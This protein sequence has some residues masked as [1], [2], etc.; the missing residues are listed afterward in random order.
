MF[1][2]GWA[3]H[4]QAPKGWIVA[5]SHPKDYQMSVDRE[6]A[7]GGK[8]SARLKSIAAKTSGF[9]TLMQTFQAETFRGKRVRMSGYARSQDVSDWA[10]LWMRVDGPRGEPL[11]FDNMQQRPIK[12]TTE[13]TRYEI[14]LD[15][16]AQAE[17]IACGL[18]LTGRGEA[19]MD[20]LKFE[21][22]SKEILT[23][24]QSPAKA[25]PDAPAN[26]DFEQN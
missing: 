8:A 11:A 16:P 3:V 17:Q 23:T 2:A 21:V 15:V 24:A 14:V 22:V 10:G 9:G 26:L 25:V 12:A 5:G 19:W 13:W 6:V 20:D 4:A 7:H 1:S 18:L